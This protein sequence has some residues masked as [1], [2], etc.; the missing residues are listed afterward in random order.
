MENEV[1]AIMGKTYKG[2]EEV[3]ARELEQ[4]GAT[5]IEIGNRAVSFKGDKKLLYK[6]NLCSRVA[7]RFLVPLLQFEANN[8][9]ALYDH[10][11]S[12]DWS[13]YLDTNMTFA[14]DSTVYSESFTHSRFVTYRVK[15]AIADYFMEKEGERPSVGLTNPDLIVNI[16]IA[17]N[18][19]TLSLDSTGE[20]LHKR[21]YRM[22]QNEAPISEAMAA[23]MLLMAGWNGESDFVDP[24]CGSGTIVIEAA[25]IALNIPPGIF[26]DSFAFE[27]WHDFDKELFQQLYEDDSEQREFTHKIYARDVSKRA[28]AFAEENAKSAGVAKYIEFEQADIADQRLA[29]EEEGEERKDMLL[30]TNP[31]YGERMHVEKIQDLYAALGK[32][33]KHEIKNG[34]AWV[35][36]SSEEFLAAIGMKPEKKITL[37][38]GD[39]ECLFCC[40]EIFQGSRQKHIQQQ[41]ESGEYKQRDTTTIEVKSQDGSDFKRAEDG[42]LRF[43]AIKTTERD[44]IRMGEWKPREVFLNEVFGDE[45]KPDMKRGKGRK[46]FSRKR[47]DEEENAYADHHRRFVRAYKEQQEKEQKERKRAEKENEGE[48]KRRDFEKRDRKFGKGKFGDRKFGDRKFGEGKFDDRNF[49]DRKFGEGKFGDRKFGEG[50]FGDKK[51]GEGKFGDRKFGDRKF[52]EGRFGDRKFGEG[53]F[54]DRKFGDRKFGDKRFG[55]K[56]KPRG[57]KGNFRKGGERES[58]GD[59]ED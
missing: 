58:W 16:H 45:E 10:A 54:G 12:I 43:D 51:F 21:G 52:G 27:K 32:F 56:N 47:D 31:P 9:D 7:T 26:R 2:M 13:M 33:L 22:V 5:E 59:T 57:G 30:V 50:K 3:L 41:V 38:N 17:G 29:T 20:S 44:G 4:A 18:H 53:K 23:G 24:M 15:D 46:D 6:V 39:I 55:G 35:I 1:F 36:S 8:A 14:V 48:E 19:C 25:L 40:Y 11:K 34:Y 49:S 37:L 42:Q 28:L